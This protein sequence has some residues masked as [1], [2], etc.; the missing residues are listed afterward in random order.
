ML[1]DD[2]AKELRKNIDALRR[3]TGNLDG[4]KKV[5]SYNDW[6]YT[7]IITEKWPQKYRDELNEALKSSLGEKIRLSK[8]TQAYSKDEKIIYELMEWTQKKYYPMK[9]VKVAG[10]KMQ[11]P[12]GWAAFAQA[13]SK[14]GYFA[15]A[16]Y[17]RA[18]RETS[19]PPISISLGSRQNEL[20]KVHPTNLNSTSFLHFF[21]KGFTSVQGVARAETPA[22]VWLEGVA[23]S[24]KRSYDHGGKIY[25]HIDFITDF[26]ALYDPKHTNF[27][28][29]TI[30]ELRY[31]ADNGL[32]TRGAVEFRLGNNPVSASKVKE[33]QNAINEYW[34]YLK[35]AKETSF[36]GAFNIHF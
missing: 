20:L 4:I 33:I 1:Y 2:G 28:G 29:G 5:G 25:F 6:K 30:T 23:Q 9:E 24:I 14:K 18:M 3:V 36:R 7:Q 27:K 26:K 35:V 16:R 17:V 15:I 31:L 8:G 12:V 34:K 19:P 10:R 32:V 11:V 13:D 22:K 21:E